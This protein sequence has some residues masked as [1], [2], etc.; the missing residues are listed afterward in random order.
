MP[1]IVS[2]CTPEAERDAVALFERITPEVVMVSPMEAEFAKLFSNAYRY[3][4]F[5]ATNEFYLVAKSA[6]VDYQRVLTRD[7]AQL[8]ARSRACRGRALPPAPA[9]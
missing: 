4:E 7:E 8:S 1:Q 6:G 2:G 5:A 3:I 9:W